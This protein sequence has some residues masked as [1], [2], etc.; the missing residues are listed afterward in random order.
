MELKSNNVIRTGKNG[1]YIVVADPAM[2]RDLIDK[3]DTVIEE[4]GA[5]VLDGYIS[6]AHLIIECA[7]IEENSK[8]LFLERMSAFWDQFEANKKRSE[9]T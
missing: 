1:S 8:D 5:S 6:L 3:I 9:E 2:L 7:H 4:S